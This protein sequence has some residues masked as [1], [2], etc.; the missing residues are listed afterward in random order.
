MACVSISI[1]F[2]RSIQFPRELFYKSKG[3]LELLGLNV[4]FLW[5]GRISSSLFSALAVAPDNI[6]KKSILILPMPP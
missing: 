2:N 3:H 5:G 1:I 6:L 4:F